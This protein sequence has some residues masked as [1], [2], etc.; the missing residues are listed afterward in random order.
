MATITRKQRE[1]LER[2]LYHLERG[3]KYI[4][5]PNIAVCVRDRMATT[6]L[7]YSRQADGT[8]LYEVEKAIGSD[9]CGLDDAARILRAFLNPDTAEEN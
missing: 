4:A 9:L 8:S 6:T 7:H 3:Q 1:T 5:K 2:A